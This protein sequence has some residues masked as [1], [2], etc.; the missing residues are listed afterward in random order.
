M[1]EAVNAVE[2]AVI[3]LVVRVLRVRI[4]AS[5]DGGDELLVGVSCAM[6]VS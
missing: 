6:N 4:T 1:A 3:R 2:E 5:T